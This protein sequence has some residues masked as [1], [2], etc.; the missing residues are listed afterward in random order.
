MKFYNQIAF[1]CILA[2][3]NIHSV[4]AVGENCAAG[5]TTCA[6]DLACEDVIFKCAKACVTDA[7]CGTSGGVCKAAAAQGGTGSTG[8]QA[9]FCTTLGTC[10][11]GTA[12]ATATDVCN[13]FNLACEAPKKVTGE[14]CAVEAD[15]DT[16]KD[17]C[18]TASKTCTTIC[19]GDTDCGAGAPVGACA[20][21]APGTVKACT[22]FLAGTDACLTFVPTTPGEKP[23]C[24]DAAL[25]CNLFNFMCPVAATTTTTVST[26]TINLAISGKSVGLTCNPLASECATGLTCNDN[27]AEPSCAMPCTS[28]FQC[29][30]FRCVRSTTD[31][32][33]SQ[34]DVGNRIKKCISDIDCSFGGRCNLFTLQCYT[35][36]TA[37]PNLCQD[38]VAGGGQNSC[39][40]LAAKGYC[41]SAL[42]LTLMRTKCQRSCGYCTATGTITAGCADLT[43]SR[44]VSECNAAYCN[45]AGYR[46]L[47]RVQCRAT[48]NLCNL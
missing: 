11:T 22:N 40:A 43:N 15:C 47:M 46:D 4:N 36:T 24:T 21:Q 25:V 17:I 1:F 28:D 19:T 7:D 31:M 33:M 8:P 9:R 45:L 29:G 35:I 5:Q 27:L 37:A 34:C 23:K 12:C 48:C 2:F 41:T 18:N 3:M 30:V 42:Y 44:G 10:V 13:E 20:V 14:A 6:T 32:T 39:S 26:T 16:T 38:Q